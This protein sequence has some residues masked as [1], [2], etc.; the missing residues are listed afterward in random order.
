MFKLYII[1]SKQT[2]FTNKYTNYW[3]TIYDMQ[4]VKYKYTFLKVHYIKTIIKL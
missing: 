3:N 1:H 2:L 4:F